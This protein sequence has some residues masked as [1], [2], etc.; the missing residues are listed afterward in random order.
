MS[1]LPTSSW[2]VWE[3]L[4]SDQIIW[5]FFMP[6]SVSEPDSEKQPNPAGYLVYPICFVVE[7]FLLSSV[8]NAVAVVWKQETTM[9]AAVEEL[10]ELL[11]QIMKVDAVP[12]DIK[13]KVEG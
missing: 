2:E 13:L 9:T 5:L 7:L 4:Y 8:C 6:L 1:E 11:A 3:I 10:L 12:A